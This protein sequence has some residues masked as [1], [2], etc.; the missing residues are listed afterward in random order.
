MVSSKVV[1]AD[2]VINFKIGIYMS[3]AMFIR[4]SCG[5][6]RC[7][8]QPKHQIYAAV[9]SVRGLVTSSLSKLNMSSI[10]QKTKITLK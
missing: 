2:D 1:V 7:Y 9:A 4:L 5:D 8:D 10:F 3:H 6:I